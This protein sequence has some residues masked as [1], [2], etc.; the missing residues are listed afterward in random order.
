MELTSKQRAQLRGMEAFA[1]GLV[2]VIAQSPRSATPQFA[3]DER[4]LFPAGDSAALARRID[5]WLEHPEER[6]EMEKRYAESAADYSL[7]N[8]ILH[9]EEMFRMRSGNGCG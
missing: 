7:E 5:Y 3:L 9:T 2:P 1:C 4:S 8:S 6:G